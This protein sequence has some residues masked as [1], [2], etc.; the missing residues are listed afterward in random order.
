MTTAL[1]AG[2]ATAEE[3]FQV[4]D[5]LFHWALQKGASRFTAQQIVNCLQEDFLLRLP[6]PET[7]HCWPEYPGT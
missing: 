4:Q 7:N 1:W 5:N 3:V 2:R 6:T